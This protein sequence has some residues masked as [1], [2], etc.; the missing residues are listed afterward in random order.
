MT[1]G[2]H[3]KKLTNQPNKI[4]PKPDKTPGG[5]AETATSIPEQTGLRGHHITHPSSSPVF[6]PL[7]LSFLFF[8]WTIAWA[9]SL[10]RSCH[11]AHSVQ[12]FCPDTQWHWFKEMSTLI[13]SLDKFLIL[14][15]N[16][17]SITTMYLG[18][19]AFAKV[20]L[21][22]ILSRSLKEFFFSENHFSHY[23]ISKCQ[24]I[25]HFFYVLI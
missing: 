25:K 7:F 15:F 4:L 16:I 10:N 1:I 24:R 6:T 21:F 5:R 20:Y 19:S 11:C 14:S 8:F 3:W 13:L 9:Q 22:A 23:V 18:H 2:N 12:G 17:L